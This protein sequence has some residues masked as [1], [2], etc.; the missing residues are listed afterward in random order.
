MASELFAN[1]GESV[2]SGGHR[3]IALTDPDALW[4]V[5]A[6][7]MDVF[8]VPIE[9][10]QPTGM[11]THLLR[12]KAGEVVF[13][14]HS[15]GD[16][17]S[18]GFIAV[19][20]VETRVRKV[21]LA[22]LKPALRDPEIRQQMAPL[23][24]TWIRGLFAGVSNHLPP[25]RFIPLTPG[26]EAQIQPGAIGCPLD[27][28]TWIQV[29]QG[30][31]RMAG[32]NELVLP[33]AHRWI[34]VTPVSWIEA[35]EEAVVQV[36]NTQALLQEE[37]I[38]SALT[39]C[40]GF[41]APWVTVN[42]RRFEDA[43][44]SRVQAKE[45]DKQYAISSAIRVLR[46]LLGGADWGAGHPDAEPDPLFAA[47]QMVG[48][49][50]GIALKPLHK[51][52]GAAG[53]KDPLLRLADASRTR[54]RRVVLAGN[55]WEQDNGPLLGYLEADGRP[56][57]LLPAGVR[58]YEI[59]DPA[60]GSRA[61]VTKEGAE[62]LKPMAFSFFRSFPDRVL[63]TPDLIRFGLC[64]VWPDITVIVL[65][66]I[67]GALL[68]LLTPVATGVIFD[69]IVP[70]AQRSQL[71]QMTLGLFV[72]ALAGLTFEITRSVAMLRAESRSNAAI[73]AAMWDRL[74]LLPIP[75]FRKF[76]AGDLAARA[77]GINNIRQHLSQ[78]VLGSLLSGVFSLFN[79]ALLFYYSS[80]LAL[81]ATGLVLLSV[82]VTGISS[83]LT[84]KYTRQYL[85]VQGKISGLV[86]QLVTGIS[87]LRVAGAEPQAYAQWAQSFAVEKRLHL[88]SQIIANGFGVFNAIFPTL[89][90]ICLFGTIAFYLK[91]QIPTGAF[92]AFNAAWG[93]FV[94][95]MLGMTASLMSTLEIIPLYQRT[96]PILESTPEIDNTKVDPGILTGRIEFSHVMFRYTEDGPL[97][98]NDLS[99]EIHPGEFV[100]VVG[101]S[102]SGKSTLLRLLLGFEAPESG[103]LFFDRLD[104]A[105]LDIA[106]VRKQLGVVLQN[107]KLIPGTIFDN[108]VGAS[109]LTLDD[110][111]DAA[112]KAGLADD[113]E[114]MPMG[115]HTVLSEGAGTISGGQRQRLMI[116]RAIVSRPR[117]VLFDEATSAL[118]NPTQAV[119]SQSL[120]QL[121][122]TRVVIAHRLS[123]IV[124]AN[125]I[126]VL[127]NGKLVQNGDY[128]TLLHQP[129]LFADLAKRQLV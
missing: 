23:I 29:R 58:A 68:N 108:I 90:S 83:L 118:D 79:L 80:M 100:A 32:L 88:K 84:L 95:S 5:E 113:I 26:Q 60:D 129:G 8:A 94:A 44:S 112:R 1:Q 106:A 37:T 4:L 72:A 124:H 85:D 49:A 102:G 64:G 98:L 107:G 120:V 21:S 59:C 110:A 115:M 74:L 114:R 119:V 71:M 16:A 123:T 40:G 65:V 7:L 127:Q 97:V 28:V 67:A 41:L 111:W 93:A 2:Q 122:A 19:G 14:L 99:F 121:Q 10:G 34:P 3:P 38:E 31:V 48:R 43:E 6:G 35:T 24:D 9:S 57:A 82:V 62:R 73:E 15:P 103:A 17:S 50:M 36:S 70:A 63:K 96:K 13:S 47:C 75:F 45:A 66:G 92:L 117:I 116:A 101:P 56:V 77:N 69:S 20:G 53:A 89:T 76:S 104:Q 11:R 105:G 22:A 33:A 128:P 42:V 126:L 52:S 61:R 87:K 86:L 54:L 46:G 25:Q 18:L 12:V 27:E 39:D 109:T 125:R 55:W 81:V 91:D 51:A 30:S 78:V